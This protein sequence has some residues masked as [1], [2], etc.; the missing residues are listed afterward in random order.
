M[1]S[2]GERLD[3]RALR[4]RQHIR[5]AEGKSL[6]D[7]RVFTKPPGENLQLGASKRI[8][9]YAGAAPATAAKGQRR[10]TIP[11]PESLAVAAE[12]DDLAGV[13]VP[14]RAANGEIVLAAAREMKIT[15]A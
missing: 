12:R 10:Y 15:A 14:E 1:M 4:I 6:L 13:L 3:E 9:Q 2:R 5:Q 7:Q 8:A 11:H